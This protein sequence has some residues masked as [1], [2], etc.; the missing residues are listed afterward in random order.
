MTPLPSYID[1]EAWQDYEAMRT[2]EKY[3]MTDRVIRQKL[4]L[5]QRYKEAGWDVNAVIDKA[6]EMK[7]RDF[8]PPRDIDIPI[9]LAKTGTVSGEAA[10]YLTEVPGK[11]SEDARKALSAARAGIR[12]V[13]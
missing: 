1:P 8:Y 11:P 9:K 7:W 13:A 4:A 10:R 12:R 2:R 6:T 3:P 5:L